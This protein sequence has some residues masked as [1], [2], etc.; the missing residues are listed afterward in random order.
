M[1]FTTALSSL[2]LAASVGAQTLTDVLTQNAGQLSSL[3][4]LVNMVPGIAQNLNQAQ[5][6][7]ILA[8][9]N[10]AVTAF[11]AQNPNAARDMNMVQGVLMYHV[12]R[13][14]WDSNAFMDNMP[15]FAE[16]ML[17]MPFANLSTGQTVELMKMNN[18]PMILSGFKQPSKVVMADVRFNGGV[19]HV[20]DTVLTVPETPSSTALNT[21]LTA[22][23]GAVMQANLMQA[24]DTMRDVTIFAPNNAAFGAVASVVR[25][26]SPQ[27]LSGVLAYHVI[28]TV[29]FSTALAM[30][31]NTMVRTLGG[32]NIAI[33]VING[34]VFVNSAKVVL[35]DVITSNGVVHVLDNVLNPANPAMTPN[36]SATTGMPAFDNAQGSNDIPFTSGVQPTATRIPAGARPETF[37]GSG[38]FNPLPVA[39]ML[40]GVGLGMFIYF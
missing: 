19:I 31:P 24:I 34:A 40:G 29:Q 18:Q 4:N 9:N 2:A 22:L 27:D 3:A 39:L 38:S 35:A 28:P 20:I 1:R 10:D 32:Q 26:A 25:N 23:A 12:L 15:M 5:N 8:P 30:S 33:S 7:T 13:G 6:I 16:T 36:P 21:G 17:G 37:T 11:L 14:V